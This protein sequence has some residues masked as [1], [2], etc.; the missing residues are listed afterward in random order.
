MKN[1]EEKQSS[2]TVIAKFIDNTTNFLTFLFCALRA[3]GIIQWNWY[4]VISPI[5]IKW[6][7][8][9]ALCA[10]FGLIAAVAIKEA[11]TNIHKET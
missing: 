1:K 5:F 7:L 4:W 6:A 9:A 10:A 2:G 11:G 3:C 8:T